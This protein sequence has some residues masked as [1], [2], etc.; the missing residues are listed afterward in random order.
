MRRN[1]SPGLA[2]AA[3]FDV[4]SVLLVFLDE[5]VSCPDVT[6]Y[7]ARSVEMLNGTSQLN[8]PAMRE[9]DSRE[10]DSDSHLL[11]DERL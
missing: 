4:V 10:R 1:L 7:Y 9:S 3:Q 6:M 8:Q 11:D 2:E 5:R